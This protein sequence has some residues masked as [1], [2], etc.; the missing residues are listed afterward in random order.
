MVGAITVEAGAV[1]AGFI[2]SVGVICL[3]GVDKDMP[4]SVEDVVPAVP[5]LLEGEITGLPAVKAVWPG[6]IERLEVMEVPLFSPQAP[7]ASKAASQMTASQD[8]RLR[9][10]KL[11]PSNQ[12]TIT[13]LLII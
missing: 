1:V 13:N 10:F 9:F 2:V 6:V 3:S 8:H 5:A 12:L 7:S 4:V 11:F